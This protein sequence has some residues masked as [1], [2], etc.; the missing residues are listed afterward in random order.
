[1]DIDNHGDWIAAGTD[2]L[3]LNG[4]KIYRGVYMG[5]WL[6]LKFD[7]MRNF[8][9]GTSRTIYH[10]SYTRDKL[11]DDGPVADW[12]YPIA[13]DINNRYWIS[14]GNFGVLLWNY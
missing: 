5:D 3:Y 11:L 8:I 13:A 6:V 9:Y 7:D 12:G 2:G 14:V 10:Y 1:M 4:R